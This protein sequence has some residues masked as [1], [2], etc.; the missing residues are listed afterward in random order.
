MQRYLIALA[1]LII[2][3]IADAI[4]LSV[5]EDQA[6]QRGRLDVALKSLPSLCQTKD[7]SCRE[8]CQQIAVGLREYIAGIQSD[9]DFCKRYAD[10]A[11]ADEQRDIAKAIKEYQADLRWA[12]Q[13]QK[14]VARSGGE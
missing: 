3:P 1:A 8:K 7:A 6:C 10:G 12:Q 2:M 5:L 9:I 4:P 14:T 11:S 13:A